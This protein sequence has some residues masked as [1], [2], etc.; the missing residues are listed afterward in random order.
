MDEF[1]SLREYQE[2]L[3]NRMEAARAGE[4]GDKVI[5][6]GFNS[7][8]K[9]YLVDGRDVL[10]VHQLTTIEPMPAA[11]AWA[12]GAANIKGS[13]HAVTD[14]SVLMGAERTKR[15]KFMV[16]SPDLLPGAAI[17]IESIS[18]LFDVRELGNASHPVEGVGHPEW[19]VG[20][21]QIGQ[22]PYFLIDMAKMAGDV[23]FSKLQQSG[24]SQ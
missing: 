5:L 1:R 13:V 7:G 3:R 18:G 20:C 24:D 11:K 14:F 9:R 10:D 23:R 15:G 16:L 21:Y 4:G 17:L 12:I 8:G 22:Q 6:L 19:I 2:Y